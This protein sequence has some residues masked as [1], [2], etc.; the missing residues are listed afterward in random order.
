[1][2]FIEDTKKE[3]TEDIKILFNA[4]KN[5]EKFSFSKYADGEYAILI[6]KNITNC[7]NWTFNA[8]KDSKYR[9]ELLYSFKYSEPG[10]YVGISCPCCVGE[11]DTNWMRDNV[12]VSNE[13]LTWANIFVNS[14]YSF[15]KE[16]F[17]PEFSNHNIILI[18][19]ENANVNNLPFKI[20]EHIQITG[21]AWK[22]NF[23]LLE[24]LPKIEYSNKLFLFCAGPLGNMLAARMWENNKNNTYIDIGSTLNS[25]L[26][27][28]NRGYLKGAETLKKTCIW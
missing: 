22:D 17:I 7:D 1:M 28:N 2:N 25:Y 16:N 3:F 23:N 24:I 11:E 27:G 26:V 21:T 10:Y 4:L 20:E 19:N 6:N 12:G 5:S 18:A 15:F 9:E 13:N 14:N 8:D